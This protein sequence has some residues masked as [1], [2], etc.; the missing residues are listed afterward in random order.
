M[1]EV[2]HRLAFD[3]E[4]VEIGSRVVVDRKRATG[5][6]LERETLAI[7]KLIDCEARQ[8]RDGAAG[9]L[10]TW[11]SECGECGATFT[12]MSGAT[13]KGFLRRCDACRDARPWKPAGFPRGPRNR[14]TLYVL[15]E[16]HPS[17][18]DPLSLF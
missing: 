14:Y 7:H 15:G 11:Q 13:F 12:Q 2:L 8:R 17:E 1:P 16:Y 10:L 3:P 9:A 4:T 18:V 6:C 5:Y